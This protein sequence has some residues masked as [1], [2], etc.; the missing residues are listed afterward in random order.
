M[1]YGVGVVHSRFGSL[2]LPW[3]S[4][5][6][7]T[8]IASISFPAASHPISHPWTG[9]IPRF[10]SI[11]SGGA[12]QTTTSSPL[13]VVTWG[14]M[15]QHRSG[16]LPCPRVARSECHRDRDSDSDGG[17]DGGSGPGTG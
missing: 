10:V 11:T 6:S 14:D 13:S 4:F 9:Y 15:R 5:F 16:L 7:L 2:P 17:S 8:L 3:G 12:L 1:S